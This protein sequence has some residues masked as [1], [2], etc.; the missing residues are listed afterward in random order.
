MSRRRL[1]SSDTRDGG[2]SQMDVKERHGNKNLLQDEGPCDENG[3]QSRRMHV[4]V[5]LL[6][7]RSAGRMVISCMPGGLPNWAS[8]PAGESGALPPIRCFPQDIL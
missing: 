3:R 7:D 5:T 2:S 1:F 6:K 8:S 4:P